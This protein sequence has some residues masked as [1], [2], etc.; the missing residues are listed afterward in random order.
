M[1]SLPGTALVGHCGIVMVTG[2]DTGVGKTVVTAALAAV[3]TARGIATTVVK[4]AQTGVL[5]HEP[6]DID[7]IRR[8]SGV[9]DV[10]EFA[11][12]PAALSPEAAARHAG[13]TPVN[14]AASGKQLMELAA[15]RLVIVEGAGGLLVRYDS[16][17]ATLADLAVSVHSSILVVASAALGTLNHTAL[18]LE[19]IRRRDLPLWGVIIGSW[20]QEPDDVSLSNIADLE[21]ISGLPLRGVLP[22]G[23][24]ALDRTT[25]A[26]VARNGL[27]PELGGTFDS[28]RW[29]TS[30]HRS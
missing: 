10:R 13:Q 8:L 4:V 27:T 25:F 24:A 26:V 19:A 20:P 5:P 9:T 7:E 11:R 2:T 29:R 6:G 28:V 23:C 30:L 22:A 18:T 1:T 15:E 21:T 3:T 12:F 14:L 16:T 17:G